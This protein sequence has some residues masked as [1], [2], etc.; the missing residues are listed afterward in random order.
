MYYF[1]AGDWGKC[2]EGDI[3]AQFMDGSWNSGE[4]GTIEMEINAVK[5]TDT[6]CSSLCCALMHDDPNSSEGKMKWAP[7]ANGQYEI[8]IQISNGTKYGYFRMSSF[9]LM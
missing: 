6:G 4:Y 2:P 1:F 5:V 3:R 7:N 8:K 9:I